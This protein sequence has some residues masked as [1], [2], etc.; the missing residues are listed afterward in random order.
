M[1]SSA[2]IEGS[3]HAVRNAE[4]HLRVADLLVASGE[5]GPALSHIVLSFEEAAKGASLLISGI[6]PDAASELQGVFSQHDLKLALGAWIAFAAWCTDAFIEGVGIGVEK[7]PGDPVAQ[8]MCGRDTYA[9]RLI[10][11]MRSLA[12]KGG[13][14]P[15][16]WATMGWLKSANHRKKRGLYVD[17]VAGLWVTPDQVTVAECQAG[18]VSARRFVNAVKVTSDNWKAL[19]S[20]E[21]DEFAQAIAPV[22]QTAHTQFVASLAS[23]TSRT[24]EP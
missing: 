12:N 23:S 17:Y 13:E 24:P 5:F 6:W 4:R 1:D 3:A 11:S 20:Q 9:A 16:P 8:L 14:V 21:R 19:N 7:A 10:E 15:E 18:I 22:L 2:A